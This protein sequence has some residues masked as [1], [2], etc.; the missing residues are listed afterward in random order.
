MSFLPG[1]D[2]AVVEEEK[3]VAYLLNAEHP[4][5]KSKARFFLGHGALAADWQSMRQVLLMHARNNPVAKVRT[6]PYG[7]LYQ[8]DCSVALPDGVAFCI[9]TVWEIRPEQACPRLVT[10]H[11]NELGE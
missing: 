1:V 2:C 6:S 11:P 9:R 10:A 5:G 8:V 7:D 4:Q 3:I